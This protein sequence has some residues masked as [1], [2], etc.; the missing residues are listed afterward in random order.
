MLNWFQHLLVHYWGVQQR[1]T[2]QEDKHRPKLGLAFFLSVL[3]LRHI[4]KSSAETSYLPSDLPKLPR[5]PFDG[6]VS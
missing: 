2:K 5:W 4:L 6:H 3:V 1:S